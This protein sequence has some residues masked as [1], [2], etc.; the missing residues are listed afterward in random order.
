MKTKEFKG[1]KTCEDV[2]CVMRDSLDF[3]YA[4]LISKD[5]S[6]KTGRVCVYIIYDVMEYDGVDTPYTCGY[7]EVTIS[8]DGTFNGVV[9]NDMFSEEAADYLENTWLREVGL[10][11]RASIE[12]LICAFEKA[13][14]RNNNGLEGKTRAKKQK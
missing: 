12:S 6:I 5:E 8:L 13:I 4:H 3:T 10:W 11:S 7:F 2:L 9:Y 1:G 14:Y